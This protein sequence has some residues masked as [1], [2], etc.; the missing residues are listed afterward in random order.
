MKWNI[1]EA[2]WIYAAAAIGLGVTGYVVWDYFTPEWADYQAGFRDLVEQK[3]GA[4]R[5]R[6]APS[7][8]QQVWVADLNRVDRCVTCH[9]GMEWKGLESAP[10]PYRSHPRDILAKH[11]IASYGCTVCHGGQGYA[12]DSYHAHATALN[13]WEEPLLYR[14]VARMYLVSDSG[15]M[16]ETNCNRCHRYDRETAGAGYLNAAKALVAQKGCRACH[17]INGRGGVIGP[18]LTYIGDQAPEQYD[19]SRMNGSPTVFGWHLAHFKE[20]KAMVATTVMPTFGFDSRAAQALAILVMSWK[21]TSV[22]VAYLPGARLADVPTPEELAK[23]KQMLTGEGAFFVKKTCFICH[24]VSTLGIESAAKI[25]PDL[26][27]AWTDVQSRFGRSLEDFL[28]SPTGTMGMVLATQIQ[29]T[30]AEKAQVVQLLKTAY[31]K[32]LAAESGKAKL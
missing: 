26:A 3:F 5:A 9:A 10:N 6:Q 20:P 24:D 27:G 22:P 4:E 21:R 19:Y 31:D 16:L 18:D 23:E 11:P 25:G 29:L 30:G 32:K 8:I 14:E 28:K 12:V 2:V 1:R 13:Y 7:G 15:A 17:K